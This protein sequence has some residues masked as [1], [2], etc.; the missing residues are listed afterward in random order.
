VDEA[1]AVDAQTGYV[2]D[3]GDGYGER[4]TTTVA[5]A[6]PGGFVSDATDCDDSNS[7]INPGQSEI[8][9]D[10]VDNDCDGGLGECALGSIDLSEADVIYSGDKTVSAVGRSVSGVGDVNADG[11]DDLVIGAP[12]RDGGSAFL[13]LGTATPTSLG[14]SEADAMFTGKAADD[15]A[16]LSVSDAG[17]VNGDGFA[18]ILV[19][20]EGNDD[21]GTNAGKAY[22]ILG[23]VTPTSLDLEDADTIYT[24]E[25]NRN[26]AGN[27]V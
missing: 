10:G 20:A 2:D 6:A 8:C 16:G 1:G 27:S 15:N 12:F 23:A 19:G 9:N 26:E 7:A 17:D 3:D 21:A 18:D 24:G 4:E 5:C 25:E 22:L 11:Y 13:I 14:V